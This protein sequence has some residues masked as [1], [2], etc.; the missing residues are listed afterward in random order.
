MST[1][2]GAKH[3]SPRRSLI[4]NNCIYRPWDL[5]GLDE[6]PALKQPDIFSKMALAGETGGYVGMD[7]DT[8]AL[9]LKLQLEDL[10]ELIQQ[11]DRKGKGK[12]GALTDI[13]LAF[14]LERGA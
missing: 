14:R 4:T 9:L 3:R 1:T 10:E 7:E 11:S 8:A 2:N 12:E 5:T 13:Q 6:T